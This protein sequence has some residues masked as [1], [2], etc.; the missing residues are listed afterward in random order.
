MKASGIGGQAVMEGI[1]MK[2]K[3]TYSIAVRKPDNEIV[4]KV[5]KY[6]SFFPA[7]TINKIPIIRGVFQFIDSMILGLSALTFSAEFF[8]DESEKEKSEQGKE[9]KKASDRF[10]TAITI[11]FSLVLA[12]TIFMMIPFW[13]TEFLGT[14]V[15]SKILLSVFEGVLR[16]IIF[17]GYVGI[18]SLLQ[19]IKRVYMYHGAE[20][21]CINCIE[22]GLPLNVENVKKS[23]TRHKRCGTSFLLIVMVFSMIFFMFIHVDQFFLKMALRIVLLPVIAGVSYEF[24]KFAGRSENKIVEILSKPGFWLQGLT[25]KEPDDKMIEVGIA[26][27][28]A[29]FDWKAFQNES[30]KL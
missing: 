12:I 7:E 20:H 10:T 3:D 13:V 18:I 5:E 17:I 9:R 28:E 19:D 6:T 11:L 21:K 1:M 8:E 15:D 27:V 22:N 23:S 4:V 16:L 25:T 29:V 24:I 2:N 26:A 30:D 14:F